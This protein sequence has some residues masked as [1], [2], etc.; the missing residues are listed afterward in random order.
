MKNALLYLWN[1]VRDVPKEAQKPI[2]G[3]RLKGMTDINP[4]WRLKAL[5]GIFGPCGTG[6]KYE[7][8]RT[9]TDK[10]FGDEVAAFVEI[11]LYVKHGDGW[12]EPIPG[13]GG[14]MLVTREKNGPYTSDECYKMALTDA[15]SVACKALGVGADV[16]FAADRSKYDKQD[17][18]DKPNTQPKPSQSTKITDEQFRILADACMAWGKDNAEQEKARLREVYPQHGYKSARDIE[19]KDF[20]Q[21][22]T[23][24]VEYGLPEGMGGSL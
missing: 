5:T 14:S 15:I 16:Y 1:Q 19:Q 6:W 9:W 23:E 17:Q 3:G 24:F 21:I 11:N 10:G 22:K 18:P 7:I 13:L 20:E 4:V 8:K 12:S 2:S